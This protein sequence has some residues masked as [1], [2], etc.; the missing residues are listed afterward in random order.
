MS[1]KSA[2]STQAVICIP[3]SCIH[4]CICPE[5]LMISCDKKVTLVLSVGIFVVQQNIHDDLL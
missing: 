4:T 3:L 1:P 5:F 2:V